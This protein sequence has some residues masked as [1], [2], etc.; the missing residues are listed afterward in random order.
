MRSDVP[1]PSRSCWAI[2]LLSGGQNR[3]LIYHRNPRGKLRSA[4]AFWALAR[5]CKRYCCRVLRIARYARAF[6]PSGLSCFLFQKMERDAAPGG[7]ACRA[8]LLWARKRSLRAS[9]RRR[10]T[11]AAR[12]VTDA[13]GGILLPLLAAARLA[14]G[15]FSFG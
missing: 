1:I 15:A 9:R 6:L 13:P 11:A 2:P 4:L 8:L 12:A 7:A 10:R 14:L 5:R 3:K